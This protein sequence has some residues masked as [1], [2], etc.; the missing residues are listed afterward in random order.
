MLRSLHIER[1]RGFDKLD[2]E[3]MGRVNLV[4]GKNNT[5][6]TSIWTRLERSSPSRHDSPG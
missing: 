5:G 1:F 2:L 3:D 4:V 6:K